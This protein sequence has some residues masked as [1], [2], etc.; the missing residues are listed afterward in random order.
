MTSLHH[1]DY[2]V[3]WICT[4]P[5]V[6]AAAKAM[7]DGIHESLLVESEDHNAY[8]LGKIRKHNVA[9]AWLPGGEYGIA[10]TSTVAMQ[11]LSSF[12]S[13]RLGDIR[14]GDIVYDLGKATRGGKFERLRMLNQPSQILLT[15]VSKLQAIH[16]MERSKIPI[17]VDVTGKNVY[18]LRRR[19]GTFD[20]PDRIA[21]ILWLASSN[22]VVKDSQLRDRLR[23]ELVA[24]CMEME[25]AGL[26][27]NYPCI[28][29]NKNWQDLQL[30]TP[31][32]FFK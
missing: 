31:K 1:E 22:Q 3:G 25:A 14:L 5:L 16:R 28:V 21:A 19:L 30:H 23:H 17:F 9:I 11:L 15:T 32:S 18:K 7:L 12:Q 8:T 13:I 20:R 24:N 4:L 26:A 6:M 29:T 27:N 2:T 10:S